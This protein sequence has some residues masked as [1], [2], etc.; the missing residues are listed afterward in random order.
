MVI[1]FMM[2]LNDSINSHKE[3]YLI[4]KHR[5]QLKKMKIYVWLRLLPGKKARRI[6]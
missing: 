1:T 3:N 6:Q 5:K 2:S 4:M